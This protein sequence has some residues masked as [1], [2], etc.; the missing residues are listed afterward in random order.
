MSESKFVVIDGNE[1]RFQKGET[2]LD[3][4]RKA[5]VEIPTLCHDDRLTPAGA[6]R[7]CLVEVDGVN[8]MQPACHT[9]VAPGMVVRTQTPR[10]DRNRQFILSLHLADTVQDR[11]AAEDNNPSRLFELADTYGTAGEWDP[12]ASP[13]ESRP[14]DTNPFIEFRADRCI[15]CSLC[16]RYCDEVE[17]VSAITL[18]HRGPRTTISTADLQSLTDTTCELCGG[19][20]D[21]CPTGA[22]TEKQAL[23]YGKPE[24]DLEKVRTTCN[25]CGVGCQIDLNIDR[26]AEHVV[27][28]TSPPPGTTVNDGNLCVK[29]RFANDFIHHE[30]RLTEPL[31][32]DEDGNLRPATWEEALD[33]VAKGLTAVRESHGNDSLAFISSS[34]CTGEENYLMQ[35]MARAAFQTHNVHQC[36]AT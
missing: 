20:V 15:A 8:L 23:I 14:Q 4:A 11:E 27:K 29:G 10:V 32:R 12:V 24:R 18:A 35:K 34:R 3:A 7:I 22:M 17:A 9:Q 6:C 26:E 21:V 1:V 5:D 30:D 16:T 13:R 33:R 36:A 19:C 28:V 25:F 31:V 2:I